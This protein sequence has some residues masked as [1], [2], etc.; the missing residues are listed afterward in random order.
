[1][2]AILA[3]TARLRAFA[4]EL[5]EFS[6]SQSRVALRGIADSSV[7]RET[8]FLLR[9]PGAH[10]LDRGPTGCRPAEPLSADR[11]DRVGVSDHGRRP[12]LRDTVGAGVYDALRI[13]AAA[14]I[15]GHHAISLRALRHPAVLDRAV[16]LVCHPWRRVRFRS[17][18]CCVAAS[19]TA[20]SHSFRLQFDSPD[21]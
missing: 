12:D 8:L 19:R 21:G 13:V 20:R 15:G 2:V 6:G 17:T 14:D 3:C 4:L 9:R 5:L 10:A 11:A 16:L 18:T 7:D 1:M